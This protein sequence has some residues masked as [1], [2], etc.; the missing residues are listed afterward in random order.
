MDDLVASVVNTIAEAIRPEK[1]ILIG[2]RARGEVTPESDIDLVIVYAGRESKRDLKLRIRKLFPR[3]R[4][5]MDLLVLT[6]DEFR[7]EQAV[8]NSA[9]RIA[10][11]EGVVCYG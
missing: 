9:G 7:R 5:S 3:Q 8:A 1:V 6:P 10:T 11:R 4:F 2:S